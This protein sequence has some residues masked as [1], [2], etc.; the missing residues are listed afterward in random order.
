[1]DVARRWKAAGVGKSRIR[2]WEKVGEV[3][4]R[5]MKYR[6]KNIMKITRKILRYVWI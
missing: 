5:F 4:T 3:Q 1:M 2:F 6:I